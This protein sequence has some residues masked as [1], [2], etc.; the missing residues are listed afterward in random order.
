MTPALPPRAT[1][2][3]LFAAALSAVDPAAAVARTIERVPGQRGALSIAGVSFAPECRFVVFAAGKAACTMAAALEEL[4]GDRIVRGLAVTKDGHAL[5][6]RSLVTIEAAHPVPDQRCERAAREA[7]A[8]ARSVG[9]EEALLVL[10]SGGA[11]ALLTAP[12]PGLRQEDLARTTAALLAEGA[13]IQE[14]NCVRKHLG[15]VSGGRLAS[16]ARGAPIVELVVSDVIGD[17]LEVIGS[18]PCTADPTTFAD[19]LAVLARRGLRERVPRTVVAYLE[20][21]AQGKR[22]ETP[23]PG[24]PALRRVV[25]RVVAANSDA[26]D[27]ARR[28]AERRGLRAIVVSRTF[29]GEARVA[30]KRLVALARALCV[31]APLVVLAGGETTVTVRGPGRG[32]RNQ[33]LALAAAL[34]L[35]DVPG[36]GLLAAGTDGS[37]GPTDAAGA[38]ADGSTVARGRALG[39]DAQQAL[40]ENDSYAFFAAEGGTFRTGPTRTNVMDLVFLARDG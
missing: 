34:A 31:D 8:L 7:L 4:V 3:A 36:I 39:L 32:G 33:E 10:L 16:H 22:L 5:P 2:E 13:D 9:P 25:A 12:P 37:D 26:L 6:L 21:G 15:T 17:R 38:F 35:K 27:A 20:A 14:L 40:L 11:S 24:D 18:G 19:A 29:A 28:E 23:K 30:G 1:L